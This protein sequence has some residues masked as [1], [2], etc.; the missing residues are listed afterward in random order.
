MDSKTQQLDQLFQRWE[1]QVPEYRGHL[2]KDGIIE[3]DLFNLTNPKILFIT[4]EPNNPEQRA[5]DFRVILL[6]AVY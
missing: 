3:E 6:S 4:K 2:V 5:D 1:E